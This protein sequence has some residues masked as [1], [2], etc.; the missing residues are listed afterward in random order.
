MWQ[1]RTFLLLTFLCRKR[2]FNES[3]FW[4]DIVRYAHT[5]WMRFFLMTNKLAWFTVYVTLVLE[6]RIDPLTRFI[7]CCSFHSC[8]HSAESSSLVPYR[9]W[10]SNHQLNWL[11]QVHSS[12]KE[13]RRDIFLDLG[14]IL[15]RRFLFLLRK[16]NTIDWKINKYL[17]VILLSLFILTYVGTYFVLKSNE[18]A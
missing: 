16:C 11:L 14:L 4:N 15:N 1:R 6:V 18:P 9:K 12:N 7:S 8:I 5:F 17:D 2:E 3:Q 13:W 10:C